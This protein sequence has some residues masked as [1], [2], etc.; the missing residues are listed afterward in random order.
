MAITLRSRREIELMRDAGAVVA[1]VLSKLQEIAR[2]GV[3][4]AH[5]DEVAAKLTSPGGSAAPV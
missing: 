2:P 4:T 5:L 1:G 3:S